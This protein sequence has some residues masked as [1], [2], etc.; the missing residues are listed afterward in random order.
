[1]TVAVRYGDKNKIYCGPH[2]PILIPSMKALPNS[3][4]E[5]S[6]FESSVLYSC[7][8]FVNIVILSLFQHVGHHDHHGH[9]TDQPAAPL[10]PPGAGIG[11]HS[12]GGDQFGQ[13]LGHQPVVQM[14]ASP[15][16][17]MLLASSLLSKYRCYLLVRL[18]TPW[19]VQ[20]IGKLRARN[21]T[22]VRLQAG[23]VS[24]TNNLD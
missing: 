2:K 15:E 14:D 9:D 1:M 10:H 18:S 17:V 8:L 19:E 4:Y 12:L 6:V 21:L 24:S 11:P 16:E 3:Q 20:M 23:L 22:P 7:K 5:S 13:G